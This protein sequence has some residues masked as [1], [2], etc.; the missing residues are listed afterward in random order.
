MEYVCWIESFCL[1]LVFKPLLAMAGGGGRPVG[2]GSDD[3]K[4]KM[5]VIERKDKKKKSIIDLWPSLP[6][7]FFNHS[8]THTQLSISLF[9]CQ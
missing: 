7:I 3:V 9:R 4:N 8:N 1:P 5:Q 6:C 2:R